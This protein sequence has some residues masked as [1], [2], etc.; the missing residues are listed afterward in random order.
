MPALAPATVVELQENHQ[1]EKKHLEVLYLNAAEGMLNQDGA[2]AQ[3]LRSA[4]ELRSLLSKTDGLLSTDVQA[5]FLQLPMDQRTALEMV[6]DH[7]LRRQPG[8]DLEPGRSL[9][10][11]ADV[12]EAERPT[13]PTER[14]PHAET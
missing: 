10:V 13:I 5:A 12:L 4:E 6:M 2:R 8:E 11:A 14:P 7:E 3:V 9:S 1:A